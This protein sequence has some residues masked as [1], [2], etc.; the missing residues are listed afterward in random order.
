MISVQIKSMTGALYLIETDSR[1]NVGSLKKQLVKMITDNTEELSLD[2]VKLF[3]AEEEK[4]SEGKELYPD[5]KRL[6]RCGVKNQS[7]LFLFIEPEPPIY[8]ILKTGQYPDK[9]LK[10]SKDGYWIEPKVLFCTEPLKTYQK[11]YFSIKPVSPYNEFFHGSSVNIGDIKYRFRSKTIFCYDSVKGQLGVLQ[12][13]TFLWHT[14]LKKDRLTCLLEHK[15]LAK[16]DVTL[17]IAGDCPYSSIPYKTLV[18][19]C[20]RSEIEKMDNL[21]LKYGV[22]DK[23]SIGY[24]KNINN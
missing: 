6:D 18:Q 21:M 15:V 23:V 2:D 13:E 8:Y 24:E 12:T 9:S 14:P 11:I 5:E 7:V 3:F 22:P 20:T 19:K 17:T 10:K 1:S 4:E 16:E